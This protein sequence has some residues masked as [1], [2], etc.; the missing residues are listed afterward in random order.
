MRGIKLS[1]V[2]LLFFCFPTC[3]VESE[4]DEMVSRNQEPSPCCKLVARCQNA[5]QKAGV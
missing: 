2:M 5:D 4:K 1:Q 3:E